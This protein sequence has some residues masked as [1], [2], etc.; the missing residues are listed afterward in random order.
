M[1]TTHDQ[2][3]TA[4]SKKWHELGIPNGCMVEMRDFFLSRYDE[5]VE[6]TRTSEREMFARHLDE[7]MKIA[8][9][10]QEIA[11]HIAFYRNTLLNTPPQ[12]NNI[13]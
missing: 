13:Q 11:D 6:D 2:L 8:H 3:K 9:T 4:I 1:S 12:V 7:I 10:P 5:G